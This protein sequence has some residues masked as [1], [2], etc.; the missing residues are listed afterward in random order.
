ME[1]VHY[2]LANDSSFCNWPWLPFS[3]TEQEDYKN[4]K[5][6]GLQWGASLSEEDCQDK[7]YQWSCSFFFLLILFFLSFFFFFRL[8]G[9][10]LDLFVCWKIV[11]FWK[12]NFRKVNYFLMFCSVMENKL[13]NIFQYLVI[14]WKISWK[15]TY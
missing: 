15:I 1:K 13:K 6:S 7:S 14:S 3:K 9:F 4:N 8:N 10:Y 11:F 5:S 12:V 2:S